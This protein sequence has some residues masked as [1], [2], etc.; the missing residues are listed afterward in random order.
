MGVIDEIAKKA[1]A[2]AQGGSA[3]QAEKGP[4]VVSPVIPPVDPNAPDTSGMDDASKAI[5]EAT[6]AKLKAEQA[7]TGNPMASTIK[8]S[9]LSGLSS[10]APTMNAAAAGTMGLPA[11]VPE[12][13]PTDAEIAAATM[14]PD[15]ATSRGGVPAPSNKDVQ[16]PLV[17]PPDAAPVSATAPKAPTPAP[18]VVGNQAPTTKEMIAKVL[19]TGPGG[20]NTTPKEA[21]N[22]ADLLKGA[23]GKLGDFLQRWGMGLQGAPTGMTQG[24]IQRAQQFELQKQ[25]IQAQVA[26]KQM[27]LENTY[28]QQRMQLQ[29]QMNLANLPIEKKAE[30]QNQMALLDAQYQQ[31]LKLIPLEIQRQFA[32][33]QWLPGAD[34]MT[35]VLD[36]GK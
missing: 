16:P 7:K 18:A 17:V 13:R 3:V 28:T 25:Q 30:L 27:A 32:M 23:G 12:V 19:S 22:F 11:Q 33:R 29:N 6:Y 4:P 36:Q 2:Q 10:P 31:Q 35:H 24:D 8:G 9:S 20:V 26:A 34:P 15:P 14:P 1:A 5:A 21:F